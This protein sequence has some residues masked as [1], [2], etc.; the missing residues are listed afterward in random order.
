MTLE[1]RVLCR[2]AL[3]ALLMVSAAAVQAADPESPVSSA[4]KFDAHPDCMDRNTNTAAGDCVVHD[5]G[6]PRRHLPAV[7]AAPQ[8]PQ[9]PATPAATP[10][11]AS[12]GT[13]TPGVDAGK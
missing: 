10:A 3:M 2:T 12:P 1:Y 6:T 5:K 7:N 4:D 13:S 8:A 11:A 9:A